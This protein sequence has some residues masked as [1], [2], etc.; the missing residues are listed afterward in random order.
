MVKY[1]SKSKVPGEGNGK[2]LQIAQ[3]YHEL[4]MLFFE[5]SSTFIPRRKMRSISLRGPI[6][7]TCDL[8]GLVNLYSLSKT[9][10]VTQIFETLKTIYP[11]NGDT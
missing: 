1:C 4:N 8:F 5:T 9:D 11:S 3:F 6:V 2:T 7:F 10:R